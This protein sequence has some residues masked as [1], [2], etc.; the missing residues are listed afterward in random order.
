MLELLQTTDKQELL[1]HSRPR[2]ACRICVYRTTFIL[3]YLPLLPVLYLQQTITP[4]PP[5]AVVHPVRACPAV[6]HLEAQGRQ[7]RVGLH[8]E[9]GG[10]GQARV[11]GTDDD[12]WGE[13][14]GGGRAAEG[15]TDGRPDGSHHRVGGARHA[16]GGGRSC[17]RGCGSRGK[18]ARSGTVLRGAGKSIEGRWRGARKLLRGARKSIAMRPANVPAVIICSVG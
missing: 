14:S 15:R 7:L 17:G 16:A 10:R 5:P 12:L 8:G 1:L 3:L 6:R 9:G 18:W 13:L 11:V 2:R 4:T